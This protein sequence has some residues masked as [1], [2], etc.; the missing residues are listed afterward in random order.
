MLHI[1][2]RL[3]RRNTQFGAKLAHL[4]KL[5]S[6][7]ARDLRLQSSGIHDLAE[8]SVRRQ[9]KQISR[10]IECTS[11]QSAFIG[12][13]LHG[14]GLPNRGLQGIQH[15]GAN[16]VVSG[17]ERCYDSRKLWR[18]LAKIRGMPTGQP[19]VLVARRALLTVPALLIH[20]FDRRQ[21]TEALNRERNVCQIGDRAVAILEV[22]GVE[23]LFGPL[24]TDLRQRL[25]HRE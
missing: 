4:G 7:Q 5:A 6:K 24:G 22:E 1:P 3:G 12:F 9:R 20:Q 2:C 23:K 15:S 17:K 16:L 18:L 13:R 21:Q 11:L 25:L 19:E 10:D 14:F 8:G